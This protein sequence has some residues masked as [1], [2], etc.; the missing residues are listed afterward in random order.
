MKSFKLIMMVGIALFLLPLNTFAAQ[1]LIRAGTVLV[2]DSP[3]AK[4]LYMFE[5]IVESQTMGDIEV[6]VYAG[7]KLGAERETIEGIQLNNIQV[8]IPSVGVLANFSDKIR[9]INLPFLLT[10]R[11]VAHKVLVEDETGVSQE[12]LDSLSKNGIKGLT[13]GD[14]GMRQLTSNREIKTVNDLKGLKLRTMKVPDHLELWRSLN[15]NPTPIAFTELYSALQQGVVDGQENP[16][17]TVYLSKFYEVQKYATVTGHIYDVQPL[18]MSQKFYDN[19]SSEYQKIIQMAADISTE[20][21]W[22][23]TG[24]QN[25]EYKAKCAKH[26]KIN[27]FDKSQLKK[28]RELSKPVFESIREAAGDEIVDKYIKAVTNA[29]Q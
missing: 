1:H 8:T 20:H 15:A 13:F 26:L 17:E 12:L 19:L 5:E 23:I 24:K 9:V 27:D 2:E 14:Y 10:N 29:K 4:C 18:L 21:M 28:C 3:A 16:W 22:Y 25:E 11:K 7:G 6:E